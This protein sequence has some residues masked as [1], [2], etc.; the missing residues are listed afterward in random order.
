[1]ALDIADILLPPDVVK[2]TSASIRFYTALAPRRA[3]GFQKR[4]ARR[5]TPIESF[6]LKFYTTKVAFLRNLYRNVNGKKTPFK[7]DHIF[8]D[9]LDDVELEKVTVGGVTT[10]QLRQAYVTRNFRD[11]SI[12]RTTYQPVYRY[13]A[14]SLTIK[15]DGT[16]T[17]SFTEV[18]GLLTFGS[19][20]SGLITA[21]T[22]KY[23]KVVRFDDDQLS[24]N[25][26]HSN[27]RTIDSCRVVSLIFP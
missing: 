22:P 11:N 7:F 3:H 4:R 10:C 17:L 24:T 19:V 21:S 13:L 6:N 20:I 8:D 2:G 27:F 1:M 26:K 23:Y 18:D 14:G 16:P 5:G 9:V 15:I 12:V 25:W